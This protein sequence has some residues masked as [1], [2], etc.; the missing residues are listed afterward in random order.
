MRRPIVIVP[1]CAKPIGAHAYHTAQDKYVQA[2]VN[3]ARCMPLVL[4]ALGRDTDLEAV[5]ATADG[6]M[7]TGSASNLHAGLY[8]EEVRDASLPLDPARDATTL[9]LIRAALR[10]GI[11]LLAI[12]RGFQE[13][14]VA[15]GGSLHQAVHDVA[16]MHD[17]RENEEFDLERQYAPVH[18]VSLREDGRMAQILDGAAE[19]MVNSLHGQ[20]IAR[21]APGLAIEAV[22]DDGLV[23]AYR[24][25]DAPGFSLA[26][27]WH[28]EWRI[29]DNPQSM[30]LFGAF[31]QACRV[32]QGKRKGGL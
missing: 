21:L 14:N 17:H 25:A 3:G 15:L 18:R 27:Q 30:K 2:V 12:C 24:V 11:P 1:A 9:P 28:P 16:G 26:L 13:V 22:A 10:R 7:L 4:P 31:G 29:A 23:E 20:G 32:Y 8:G 19:M 6:V 5:L